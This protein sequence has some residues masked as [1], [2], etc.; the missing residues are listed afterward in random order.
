MHQYS[1]DFYGQP[2][3][4]VALGFIRWVLGGGTAASGWVLGKAACPACSLRPVPPL[5]SRQ[6][7][8]ADASA[9][10]PEVRFSG[11]QELLARINTD[12]GI[13]RSQLDLPLWR[14][15]ADALAAEAPPRRA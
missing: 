3:R 15:Y 12:I 10:R 5:S 1:Q 11:L 14:P 8:L 6:A 7:T 2:L 9:R 4:V 13:A